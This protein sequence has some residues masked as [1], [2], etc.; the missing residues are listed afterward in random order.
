MSDVAYQFLPQPALGAVHRRHLSE[1][2]RAMVAE[3]I[4]ARGLSERCLIREARKR[5]EAP[6][7][8]D[9]GGRMPRR[10]AAALLNIG[11][12]SVAKARVVRQKGIPEFV[13]L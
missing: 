10:E 13:S 8:K 3:K 11:E 5:G 12:S 9:T 4:A 7:S 1:S 2:Q 6:V